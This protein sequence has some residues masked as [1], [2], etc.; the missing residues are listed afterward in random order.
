MSRQGSQEATTPNVS[1]GTVELRP[2][3]T[4]NDRCCGLSAKCFSTSPHTKVRSSSTLEP[5]AGCTGGLSGLSASSAFDHERQRLVV[6]LDFFGGVLGER[7]GLGDDGR[8]PFA[9]IA[10]VPDRERMALDLRRIEPVHQGIGRGRELF[11]G[12]HIVHARHRQRRRSASIETMRAAGCGEATTATCSMP[13]S[14]TSAT[15]WPRPAT[16]RRS[17]RTL[18]LVETK[19]KARGIGAHFA[20]TTDSSASRPGAAYWPCAIAPR[21]TAPPRRSAHSRCSGR[22]C[23]RSPPRCPRASA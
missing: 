14:A 6:D 12:Q 11:A 17:S 20:S 23:R 4:R 1:I 2:Q 10:R 19:R 18:R 5:C 15:K 8:D 9:G 16:K 13:S 3:V 22:Y 7:A 21:R